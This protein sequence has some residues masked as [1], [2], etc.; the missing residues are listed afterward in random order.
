MSFPRYTKYKES[1]VEWLGQ[2]PEH[3]DVK[4]L[5]HLA[6]IDSC[7][8]YGIEADEAEN[9]LPVA[10]TAQIDSHGRFDVDRMPAR[11]FSAAEIN[12][13]VCS[14]GDILVVKSSGSATNIISGKAGLVD[15]ITPTFVF[16]NFLMRVRPLKESAFPKFIY[17]LLRSNLTRQRVELMCS[18]TTYPNLQIGDYTSAPLPVP[19]LAEQTAIADFLDRETAKIDKLIAEQERL[20]ELLKEKRQAVISHAVTK[21]L[22]PNAPIKDSGIEWIGQVPAHWEVMHL[23]RLTKT[24][25]SITYGI[26]QAGPDI[27]GGIPYIR[28]SDMSGESLPETGYMRTTPE[29]DAS[30]TRSKVRPNDMVVAIRASLGKG[31]LVPDFL[32]GA[33]LTQG[34]ARICPGNDLLPRFLLWSFNSDHCQTSI[35]VVAKGTTFLEITLDALRRIPLVIPPMP[36]QMAI[37]ELLDQEAV[38]F[39]TLISEAQKAISLL[40][41]RRSALISAAV[42]GQ[43]DVRGIKLQEVA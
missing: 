16:S 1:G 38:K 5:K 43:I 22:N 3:W 39:D 7:G 26:V 37:V 2:V 32:D 41:E 29:I 17:A 42:T 23:R 40:Q 36:E 18:T 10:T 15:E 25:T 20:I 24:G 11:G 14:S 9:V 30:Y 31:L 8:C 6:E 12:R 28:T 33:N 19:P 13:F 35:R 27:E 34:T 21:G 4:P